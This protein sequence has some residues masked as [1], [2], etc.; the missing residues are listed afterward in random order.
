MADTSSQ[1]VSVHT[2][3]NRFEADVLMEAL[4]Q[5]GIPALLR[6]FE[7]TPYT[8]LF[9]PQRGW[10][11]VL[12]PRE[13]ESEA[14]EI[15]CALIEDIQCAEPSPANA[16]EIDPRLWERLRQADLNEIINNAVV[17]YDAE[18]EAFVV[19]FLNTAVLCY[20]ELEKIEVIGDQA[21]FSNDFELRL[22]VLHYLIGAQDRRLANQWV[23]EKDLPSGGLFFRGPHA[24]PVESLTNAFDAHTELLDLGAK[25]I[26]AE[27]ANLGDLSYL[28]RVLPRI[29]VL[30]VFWLGD[31]EFEPAFHFLFDE[32]ITLH[33]GSLDLIWALVNVFTRI[34]IHSAASFQQ[35]DE[36]E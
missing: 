17:E 22:I 21:G 28:F 36:D 11:R 7:E 16:S 18:E 6:G 1:F 19:P 27:K 35:G 2:L 30:T 31:E 20:P 8:G 5:E 3:A 24:L 9:I 4:R 32:T 10:G 23:S 26:G 14:R 13:M 29:P 25:K 33:L 15:I 34:L 12:V